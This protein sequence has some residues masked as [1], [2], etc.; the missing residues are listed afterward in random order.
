MLACS[1]IYLPLDELA[2]A[3]WLGSKLDY[4]KQNP[5]HGNPKKDVD[6]TEDQFGNILTCNDKA[7]LNSSSTVEIQVDLDT[8]R[9]YKCLWTC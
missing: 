2:A 5:F 1:G 8:D 4:A 3:A 6:I 7:N 9:F